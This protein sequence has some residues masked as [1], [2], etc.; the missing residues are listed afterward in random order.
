M[1]RIGH[2][3]KRVDLHT[4]VGL[5]RLEGVQGIDVVVV[6]CEDDLGIMTTLDDIVQRMQLD[7]PPLSRHTRERLSVE[8]ATPALV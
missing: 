5:P 7:Q 2:Q 8:R 3:P 4:V 1:S 6:P